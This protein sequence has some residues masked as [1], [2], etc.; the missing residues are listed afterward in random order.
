M[1]IG[2]LLIGQI[3]TDRSGGK[4]GD[5]LEQVSNVL[6]HGD[7][8][9]WHFEGT[10]SPDGLLYDAHTS[11]ARVAQA[12]RAIVVPVAHVYPADKMVEVH[13]G[14]PIAYSVLKKLKP[15][16]IAEL[17]VTRV[18]E[19]SGQQRAGKKATISRKIGQAILDV[20]K[21]SE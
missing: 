20:F 10:R 11:F 18:Q 7:A 2:F 5:A 3:S 8:A 17:V 19:M 15:Y 4:A 1:T 6:V 13:F 21:K 12:T 16:E 14:D 9:G